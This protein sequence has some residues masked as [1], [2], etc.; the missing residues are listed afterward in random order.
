MAV[1][2]KT[3]SVD[4][5]SDSC[6]VRVRPGG[7]G[8]ETPFWTSKLC[9][10]LG[11]VADLN[12]AVVGGRVETRLNT[13]IRDWHTTPRSPVYPG[14]DEFPARNLPLKDVVASTQWPHLSEVYWRREILPEVP[15]PNP[16]I[17]IPLPITSK[18]RVHHYKQREAEHFHLIRVQ[19][20]L[21]LVIVKDGSNYC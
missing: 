8:D 14:P 2:G 4:E 17:P 19:A 10:N 7:A 9:T 6:F 16:Q 11:R 5:L 3:K 1:P 13:N 12:L 15:L 20:S 21:E 18:A